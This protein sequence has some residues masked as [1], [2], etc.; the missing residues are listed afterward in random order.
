MS[1]STANKAIKIGELWC[2]PSKME[3]SLQSVSGSDAGRDQSGKMQLCYITHKWKISLE[4]LCPDL[5]TVKAILYEVNPGNREPIIDG[6]K[7][8]L[9]TIPVTF[10]NPYTNKE[11]TKYMYVG[12]RVMPYQ[13][14]GQ[15]RKFFSRLAF[16]LIEI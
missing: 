16:D 2:D 13:M 1:D 7:A 9:G 5:D 14:W 10:R 12:D 4:W 6:E 3:I 15:K 11:V 8:Q